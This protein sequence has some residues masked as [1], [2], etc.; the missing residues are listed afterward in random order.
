MNTTINSKTMR[1]LG[2][3]VDLSTI[4]AETVRRHGLDEATYAGKV[5]SGDN[6]YV[7]VRELDGGHG[8]WYDGGASG[9][10][11]Y[12]G[13]SGDGEPRPDVSWM[14]AEAQAWFACED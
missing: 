2:D 7:L 9:E 13:A 10:P 4:S 6:Q 11:S 5:V 14:P 8:V 1:A 3:H 12:Y